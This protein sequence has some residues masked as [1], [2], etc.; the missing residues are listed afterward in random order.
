[1]DFIARSRTNRK[2]AKA[3]FIL[4]AVHAAKPGKEKKAIKRA[5]RDFARV[6]PKP[7]KRKAA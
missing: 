6:H 3:L 5:K 7:K 4:Q 1:M 2:A